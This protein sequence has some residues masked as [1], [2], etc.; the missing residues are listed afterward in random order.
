M[1]SWLRQWLDPGTPAAVEAVPAQGVNDAEPGELGGLDFRGA[2]HAHMRWKAR[3]RDVIEGTSK[4]AI[5]PA[6]LARDDQCPLGK[7]LH[8]EGLTDYGRNELFRELTAH[9]AEFHLHAASVLQLAH[10]GHAREATQALARGPYV[11]SSA[12][13]SHLLARLFVQLRGGSVH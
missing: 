3:L 2:I 6:V 12:R 5:T 13:V 1:F 9:H 8:G 10:E 4:E 11:Q 7:W